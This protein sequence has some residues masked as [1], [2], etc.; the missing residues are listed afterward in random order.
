VSENTL[1]LTIEVKVTEAIFAGRTLYFDL[2]VG[3]GLFD[4]PSVSYEV[5]VTVASITSN[6]VEFKSIT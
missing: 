1:E 3:L 5:K 6:V 2:L 4:L